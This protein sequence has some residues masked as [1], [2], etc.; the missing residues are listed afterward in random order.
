MIIVCIFSIGTTIV[1]IPRG[2]A[3][4]AKQD[5]WI[6][7]IIAVFIGF[8]VILLLTNVSQSNSQMTFIDIMKQQFGKPIGFIASLSFIFFALHS[9]AALLSYMGDFL[10]TQILTETPTSIIQFIIIIV[11]SFAMKLG[12]ESIARSTE[13]FFFWILLFLLFIFLFTSP[14]LQFE[15]MLPLMES[16]PK[17]IGKGALLYLS[18]TPFTLVILMMV[19]P[20]INNSQQ[21]KKGMLI[22]YALAGL[23]IITFTFYTILILGPDATARNNV[24]TYLIA[25]KINLGPMFGRVEA[26][27]A[28]VWIICIFY[29]LLFYFYAS[30]LGVTQ[31]FQLKD[32]NSLIL[33]L[34]MYCYL[35][36]IIVYPSTT[37]RNDWD[38]NIFVA[39]SLTHGFILPI[40]LLL[41]TFIRQ[42]WKNKQS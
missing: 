10:S 22:G 3:A 42:K 32:G 7:I 34:A 6:A 19:F 36:S 21:G 12:I 9:S 1:Q 29:K 38:E 39:Y 14:L 31:L 33:P 30:S 26:I 17:Q 16:S 23:I 41:T 20:A 40:V 25:K 27:L 5:A 37:Y 4:S 35:L 11:I 28:F 18:V 24:P 2:L 13:I 15:N 8:F